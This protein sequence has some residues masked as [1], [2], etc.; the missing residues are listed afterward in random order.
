MVRTDSR[1]FWE[2]QK[3]F[4]IVNNLSKLPISSWNFH[5]LVITSLDA[6]DIL[7]IS[8]WLRAMHEAPVIFCPI[9]IQI[10]YQKHAE[11][12]LHSSWIKFAL[13]PAP[14]ISRVGNHCVTLTIH[15]WIVADFWGESIIFQR[16]FEFG[17]SNSSTSNCR[18]QSTDSPSP[19][20]NA[21]VST[22]AL[23]N[24]TYVACIHP[25][26]ADPGGS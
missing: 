24:H 20:L 21:P 4:F 12:E 19:T 9:R 6:C 8:I 7:Y 1:K 5:L 25:P 17:S 2:M 26:S 15:L 14:E 13:H 11:V 3:M 23:R 18:H 16:P 10:L 22:E